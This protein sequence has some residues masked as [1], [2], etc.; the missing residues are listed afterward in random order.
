VIN[1][2]TQEYGQADFAFDALEFGTCLCLAVHMQHLKHIPSPGHCF[3]WWACGFGLP[4]G[5][6][7]EWGSLTLIS[8][9]FWTRARCVCNSTTGWDNV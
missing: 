9:K 6:D 4:L 1:F 7:W 2:K 5:V 3:I 8:N